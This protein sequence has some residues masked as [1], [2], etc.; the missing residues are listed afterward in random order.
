[1]FLRARGV[2]KADFNSFGARRGNDRVMTRGTFANIRLRNLLVPGT[3]GGVTEFLPTGEKMSIF[4]AAERYRAAGTRLVVLA[5]KEYGTGSSRDWAAKGTLLLG[6]RAVIAESFER[7]HR[8]NL[9]GM[10]VLPLEFEAGQSRTTLGLTGRETFAIR[11]VEKGVDGPLDA[12]RSW[13]GTSRAPRRS[14]RVRCRDRHAHRGRVLPPRRHPAVRAAEAPRDVNP[15]LAIDHVNLPARD[16]DAL[17][18]WYVETLG[19]DRHGPFLWSGGSLLVFVRGEPLPT[20]AFHVGCRAASRAVLDGWVD[21]L[22]R[23]GV[24]VPAATGDEAYASTRLRD[25][26]GN[27]LELFHEPAPGA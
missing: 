26:E 17:A 19:F 22:R 14:F 18:R 8:S 25:P 23:R 24:D 15:P 13:R 6:V 3:E 7:I 21:E 12:R 11:G 1:M 10:G 5:G 16:P 20:G 9:V 4:D 2:A 27:E